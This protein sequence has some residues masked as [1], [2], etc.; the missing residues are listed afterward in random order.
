MRLNPHDYSFAPGN[1]KTPHRV[2]NVADGHSS[3]LRV[4][5]QPILNLFES[6]LDHHALSPATV[7]NYVADLRAFARWQV[8]HK[9]HPQNF[10]PADFRA[11]RDHLCN[12][13]DQLP[14]TVNRRLQSLRLFGRFLQEMGHAA[15]NP[16]R[17][18]K[19][20]RNGNGHPPAPRMLSRSESYRLAESSGGGR[21]S[22]VLRDRAIMHLML[23][24]GLRVAEV[25]ALRLSD[26]V[27]TRK[28]L[29]I[30][31]DGRAHGG[32]RSVPL[33]AS[34]AR[35]LRDYMPTRP[36][37]PRV[38]HLFLS[39]RGRALSVRSIQRSIDARARA[40]GLKGVCAQS[41]RHT[42]AKNML[43]ETRDVA[44][45]ARWLGCNAKSLER[46]AA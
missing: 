40:A 4:Q 21:P 25:A 38:D 20:L 19:L 14:A 9:E 29:I 17:E 32:D 7:R 27:A 22:L 45:V 39:Q 35:A 6:Y 30:H 24:A 16:T 12:E 18:I 13:T 11:Y 3:Y 26:M 8:S 41:L 5:L 42:C 15:E 44:C 43:E 28:G 23:Q 37:I 34:A 2:S 46:Y 1:R 31:V 36:A 10:A 33:N